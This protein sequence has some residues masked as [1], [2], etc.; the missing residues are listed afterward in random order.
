M[1][2]CRL[3]HRPHIY[4]ASLK[5][6]SSLD[7][8]I[9]YDDD[10]PTH[11]QLEFPQWMAL[12][13]SLNIDRKSYNQLSCPLSMTYRT[14]FHAAFGP[15]S[16]M[17]TDK[18]KKK[19]RVVWEQTENT[20]LCSICSQSTPSLPKDIGSDIRI[21]HHPMVC[22]SMANLVSCVDSTLADGNIPLSFIRNVTL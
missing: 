6:R 12:Q 13:P 18:K 19:S 1:K 3:W 22:I 21:V 4:Y 9:W 10:A 11:S 8:N 5:Q 16:D 15:Q 7:I 2:T 20:T 14:S 17:N